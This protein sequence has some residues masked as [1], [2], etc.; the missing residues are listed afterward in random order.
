VYPVLKRIVTLAIVPVALSACG[1]RLEGT[2]AGQGPTF[3]QALTFDSDG[4]VNVTFLGMTRQGTYSVDGDQVV[5][6][7]GTDASV[8]TIE[9]GGC[10]AGGG[11][12]GTYCKSGVSPVAVHDEKLAG[13]YVA[14]IAGGSIALDFDGDRAVRMTM[15]DPNG[16]TESGTVRYALDGDRVMIS[17]P[18]GQQL[19]LT[20]A[21]GKLEGYMGDLQVRFVRR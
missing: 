11:F 20:H 18:D 21:A 3:L 8:F 10:L 14:M 15:I 1:T 19:E 16:A 9:D 17:G 5:V 12:L 13:S 2:Y 4:K 7:I 6:T